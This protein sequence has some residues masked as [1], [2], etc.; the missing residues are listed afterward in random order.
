MTYLQPSLFN[1]IQ[2]HLIF[3]DSRAC[4][5]AKDGGLGYKA[6]WTTMEAL[7]KLVIEWQKEDKREEERY[8]LGGQSSFAAGVEAG[9][10]QK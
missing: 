1:L 9:W 3:D 10:V 2:I 4:K 5:P 6:P 7:C 8:V